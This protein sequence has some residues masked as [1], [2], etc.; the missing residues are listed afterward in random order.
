[1]NF[2]T[3]SFIYI[4]IVLSSLLALPL[5]A[6]QNNSLYFMQGLPQ[7]SLL[8][9][10]TQPKCGFYLTFPSV[11]INAGNS[12]LGFKDFLVYNP[13][14]DSLFWFLH[15]AGTRSS[16]LDRIKNNANLFG[17]VE[18]DLFSLGFRVNNTYLSFSTRIKAESNNFLPS[19]LIRFGVEGNIDTI[20]G[21]LRSYDFSGF[22]AKATCYSEYAIGVSHQ[23]G[24]NLTVGIRAKVL[25]GIADVNTDAS[26]VHMNGVGITDYQLRSNITINSSVPNLNVVTKPNGEVDSLKFDDIKHGSQIRSILANTK[27]MGLGLDLGVV[28]KPVDKI[29]LSMSIL[30]IGYIKWKSNLHSF[31]QDATYDFK[32]ANIDLPHPD[33]MGNALLDSLKDHF[34][35][36]S[37]IAAYKTYLSPKLYVGFLFQ[38]TKGIG[39]GA[40]TR[41]QIIE[42][43]LNSQYT[44]SLN[45]YPANA[46]NFTL[47]YTIANKMYDNFGMGFTFK[48]AFL[49]TYIMTE[50]IPLVFYPTK[51]GYP[52]PKYAKEFNLRFGFNFVLGYNHRAKKKAQG[53]KPYVDL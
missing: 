50:R 47:S 6:Q 10:A 1:M 12:S 41:Q 27:N 44:F 39:L 36:N 19:D 8:N 15:D 14:V 28:Y 5:N 11:E 40:L 25:F 31:K 51:Q 29:S 48:L 24:E 13:A 37:S 33:S 34:T 53:D 4:I 9:P 52:I 17:G 21:K 2:V 46:L 22:G 3:R 26:D 35:Y 38:L 49:Q 42:S 45:L 43:K 23:F 7:S 30:D 20:S 18:M 16:F 32:G